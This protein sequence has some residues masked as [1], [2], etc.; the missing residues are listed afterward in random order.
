MMQSGII[1]QIKH[2]WMN[3]RP[4][5]QFGIDDALQLGYDNVCFPFAIVAAGVPISVL[6]AVLECARNKR[7]V[8]TS[9][10]K[11]DGHLK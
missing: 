8:K 2:D 1:D 3:R 4:S 7:T 10:H 5:E 11:K 6:V 9:E